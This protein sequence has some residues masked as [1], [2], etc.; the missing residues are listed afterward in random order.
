MTTIELSG[1]YNIYEFR[2]RGD[3]DP[4]K[5]IESKRLIVYYRR[6]EKSYEYR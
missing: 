1:Q 5:M 6:E 3:F 2:F 4:N